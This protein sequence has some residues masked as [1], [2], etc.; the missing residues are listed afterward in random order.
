VK[1]HGPSFFKGNEIVLKRRALIDCRTSAQT[2]IGVSSMLLIAFFSA[3]IFLAH[4][5]EA[6]NAQ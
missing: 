1:A 4:A 3:G 2:G 5:V 6:Y